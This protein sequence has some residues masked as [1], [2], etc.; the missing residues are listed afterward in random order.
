M[1]IFSLLVYL[2]YIF[3]SVSL[4]ETH[5]MHFFLKI[6][7]HI[8]I[9]L[10]LIFLSRRNKS[11]RICDVSL[12]RHLCSSHSFAPYCPSSSSASSAYTNK[13]SSGPQPLHRPFVNSCLSALTVSALLDFNQLSLFGWFSSSQQTQ[14]R[15]L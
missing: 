11:D 3:S 10:N 5:K 9:A 12:L 15:A 6:N 8:I 1:Q 2:H 7:Q 4:K 13:H 14:Y